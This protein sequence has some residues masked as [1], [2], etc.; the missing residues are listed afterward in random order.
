MDEYSSERGAGV[1][2]S[3]D[4]GYRKNNGTLQMYER[5]DGRAW[6]AGIRIEA[7]EIEAALKGL[8]GVQDAAV[9]IAQNGISA[10]LVTADGRARNRIS[11]RR[12]CRAKGP[13]DHAAAL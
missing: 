10:F 9:L 8:D 1:Y 3:G 12:R 5:R 4:M 7:A 2:R 6:I 13:Q 11:Y